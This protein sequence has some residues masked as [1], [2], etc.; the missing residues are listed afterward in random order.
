MVACVGQCRKPFLSSL[1]TEHH[2]TQ[3]TSRKAL[4]HVLVIGA[5][6]L[7]HQ[8]LHGSI[9]FRQTDI[10]DNRDTL[11]GDDT[12]TSNTHNDTDTQSH[13]HLVV[14]EVDKGHRVIH[15]LR[16]E[17]LELIKSL[18]ARLKPVPAFMFLFIKLSGGL[19]YQTCAATAPLGIRGHHTVYC[20]SC[21]IT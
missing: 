17:L 21:H 12:M 6:P 9:E 2:L 14:H 10:H 11:N 3:G 15:M 20:S 8:L 1:S 5:T 19:L 18:L 4:S 7:I 13:T 16:V